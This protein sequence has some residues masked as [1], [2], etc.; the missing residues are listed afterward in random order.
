MSIFLPFAPPTT[1]AEG[2]NYLNDAAQDLR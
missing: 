2:N 1:E